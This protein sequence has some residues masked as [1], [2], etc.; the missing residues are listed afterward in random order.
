M[1]DWLNDFDVKVTVTRDEFPESLSTQFDVITLVLAFPALFA[2]ATAI[3]TL[4]GQRVWILTINLHGGLKVGAHLPDL[5]AVS[6]GRTRFDRHEEPSPVF[7]EFEVY[8]LGARLS[9]RSIGLLSD[10]DRQP[11]KESAEHSFLLRR[12][13]GVEN[14][15]YQFTGRCE[16]FCFQQIGILASEYLK[17]L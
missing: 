2:I 13:E 4:D 14:A 9:M 12:K 11:L 5:A 1:S 7:V 17:Q 10:E 6:P 8:A 3:D 16:S 15:L